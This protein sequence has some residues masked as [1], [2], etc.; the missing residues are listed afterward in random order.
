MSYWLPALIADGRPHPQPSTHTTHHHLDRRY[1]YCTKW[2]LSPRNVDCR[3]VG[4]TGRAYYAAP[5]TPIHHPGH[6]R[7]VLQAGSGSLNTSL[8]RAVNCHRR[9]PA[10]SAPDM[11]PVLCCG[12]YANCG[13]PTTV[14]TVSRVTD[15]LKAHRHDF[16]C[17]T[18]V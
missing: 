18:T 8:Q 17:G 4:S 1:S 16:A 3:L 15:A 9:V 11:S 12:T 6:R 14:I 10:W 13:T 2:L 5:L 7:R